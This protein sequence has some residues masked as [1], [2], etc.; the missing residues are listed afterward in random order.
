MVAA[1]D[2]REEL[3][4]HLPALRALAISLTGDTDVA[5]DL[6]QDALEKAWTHID[7]FEPGTNMWGW[8][9][10]ILRNTWYSHNRRA[11]RE[12][13]RDA[14]DL[15]ATLTVRPD[16]DGRLALREI[17]FALLELPPGQRMAVLLVGALGFSYDEAAALCGVAPG[18]MK[19]RT[20]RGRRH[21]QVAL[22]LKRTRSV[23]QTDR[24]MAAAAGQEPGIW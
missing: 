5:D 16:H 2:P 18:T 15:G 11:W 3:V 4:E 1:P 9:F 14:G 7:G 23:V 17:R 13:P 8:L 20:N 22:G 10:T 19:S 24:I 12:I 21:L 6:L